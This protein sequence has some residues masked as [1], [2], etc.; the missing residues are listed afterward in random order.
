MNMTLTTKESGLI[1]DMK[2][3]ESLCIKKYDQYAQETTSV[4]LK[5][6]FTSMAQTER[7][8]LK[9]V[10]DMMNGS[11]TPAPNTISNADNEYCCAWQYKD[12]TERNRDKF[13][14]QDMLATEKHASSLYDTSVFEFTDPV[15][16]KVLNHIQAEEQ[17]H[18]ERLYAYMKANG[19]YN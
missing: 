10:T 2:D 15:A 7:A 19:M 4:P 14:C 9:T 8:H 18:G 6:L 13:F 12:E 11:V 16:R 3:Q 5:Q 17:Q 1:K